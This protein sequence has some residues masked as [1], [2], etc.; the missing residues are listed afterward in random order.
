MWDEVP[1]KK[2]YN[3]DPTGAMRQIRGYKHMLDVLNH[4]LTRPPEWR[5]AAAGVGMVGVPMVAVFDY[6]MATPRWVSFPLISVGVV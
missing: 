6:V 4:V 1:H 5:D 2:P 3:R